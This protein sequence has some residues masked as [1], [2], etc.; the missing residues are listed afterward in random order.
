[1]ANNAKGRWL[2][3]TTGVICLVSAAVMLW[4]RTADGLTIDGLLLP[5]TFALL[6]MFWL[7]WGLRT[8]GPKGA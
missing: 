6:G 5:V 7:L 3:I 8:T 2:F 4:R 1:M